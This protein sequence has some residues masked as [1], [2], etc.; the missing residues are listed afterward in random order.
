MVV[1]RDS[2]VQEG[3]A[4]FAESLKQGGLD[5]SYWDLSENFMTQHEPVQYEVFATL[6]QCTLK[7]RSLIPLFRIVVLP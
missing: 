3:R 2:V 7:N 6:I 4:L 5:G 1:S